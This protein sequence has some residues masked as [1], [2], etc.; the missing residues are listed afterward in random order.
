MNTATIEYRP[1]TINV[2]KID[3]K[4]FKTIAKAMDWLVTP[5]V[6][7]SFLM[8]PETGEYFNEET[9]KAFEEAR[10]D[11]RQGRIYRANSAEEMF[12]QILG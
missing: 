3:V 8:D 5:V 10:E 4:R 9:V 2:P 11:A 7:K 12:K 6:E 1:F